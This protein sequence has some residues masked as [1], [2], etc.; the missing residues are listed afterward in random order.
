MRSRRLPR[1]RRKSTDWATAESAPRTLRLIRLPLIRPCPDL[2]TAVAGVCGTLAAVDDK[3]AAKDLRE[4]LA[5]PPA[6]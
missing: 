3:P 1:N 5:H 6:D 4:L 2:L